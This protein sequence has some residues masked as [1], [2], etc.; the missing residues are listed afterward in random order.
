MNISQCKNANTNLTKDIPFLSF[1][2][3]LTRMIDKACN[4][5]DISGINNLIIC[6]PHKIC[7]C[8]FS[9][10]QNSLLSKICIHRENFTHIL[11]YKSSLWNKLTCKQTVTLLLSLRGEHVCI[12]MKLK[13]SI[14][15]KSTTWTCLSTTFCRY[16]FVNTSIST[17]KRLQWICLL[18]FL[19]TGFLTIANQKRTGFFFTQHMPL[20]FQI[21]ILLNWYELRQ[22]VREKSKSFWVILQLLLPLSKH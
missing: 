14:F 7:A 10:L 11:H 5:A 3:R 22:R 12:L 8:W 1:T 16:A 2:V 13:S 17:I 6:C 9:I 20:A 4:I 15:T 19:I 18:I 21:F